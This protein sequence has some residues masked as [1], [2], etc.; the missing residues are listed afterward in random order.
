MQDA[1]LVALGDAVVKAVA[2]I[3]SV[4]PFAIEP[5]A[6]PELP[7]V[8]KVSIAT[9]SASTTAASCPSAWTAAWPRPSRAD[10]IVVVNDGST[11]DTAQVLDGY[12]ARLRTDPGHPAAQRRHLRRRPMPRSRPA[13]ARWCCCW[14]PTTPWRRNASR[15]CW[16]HCAGG[17]TGI[18]PGWTHNSMQRFS[19]G[20]PHLG[21]APYYPGGQGPE[22][23]LAAETLK[24]ASLPRA[25]A[26]LGPGLPARS[27]RGHRPPGC[28]PHDVPGPAAVHRRRAAQPDAPGF[29]SR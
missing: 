23:W 26:D 13:P 3:L 10:E 29:P 11:D 14:M 2:K 21:L 19:E 24:A 28:R 15:R 4:A 17:W 18:C 1:A 8:P 6:L 20:Q 12:A 25:L 9:S 5:M 16:T 27:P 22:G 7:A